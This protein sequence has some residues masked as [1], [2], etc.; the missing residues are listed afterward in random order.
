MNIKTEDL[1]ELIKEY[2][3]NITLKQLLELQETEYKYIC[4]K[5]HGDGFVNVEKK[6]YNPIFLDNDGEITRYTIETCDL[7]EGVGYTKDEYEGIIYKFN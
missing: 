1:I 3:N 4:N 6:N 2:G 5:C 7:C